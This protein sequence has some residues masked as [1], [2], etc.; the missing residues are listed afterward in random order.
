MTYF[1]YF[2][3]LQLFSNSILTKKFVI[4]II[5]I[6]TFIKLCYDFINLKTCLFNGSDYP[7]SG[8]ERQEIFSLAFFFI[9]WVVLGGSASKRVNMF[10]KLAVLL[11]IFLIFA[12]KLY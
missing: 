3:F 1:Y 6:D 2:D 9:L 10:F 5:F 7:K 11:L 12:I 8:I 4:E